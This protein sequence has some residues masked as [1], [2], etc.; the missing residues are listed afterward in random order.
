MRRREEEKGAGGEEEEKPDN[1]RGTVGRKTM[2]EVR[3]GGRKTQAEVAKPR[4]GL[5]VYMIKI[6][7][8]HV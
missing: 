3:L 1:G 2:E 5:R 4:K 8:M 7:H 6:D